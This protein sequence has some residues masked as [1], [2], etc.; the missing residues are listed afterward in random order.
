M[1]RIS[2]VMVSVVERAVDRGFDSR[3][4]QII[5]KIGICCFSTEHASLRTKSETC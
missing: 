4:S 1:T 5:Y 3:S 2:G